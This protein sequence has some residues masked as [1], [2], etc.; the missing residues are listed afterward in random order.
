MSIDVIVNGQNYTGFI[1]AKITINFLDASGVASFS[2][3]TLDLENS[4][5]PLRVQDEVQVIIN[6]EP[7]ITGFI[8]KLSN[9]IDHNSQSIKFSMRDK[10]G[11]LVDSTL[12][13]E[14]T[15]EINAP[16]SLKIIC[17][18]ILKSLNIDMNVIDNSGSDDFK[19]KGDIIIPKLKDTAFHFLEEY[20]QKRQVILRSDGAGNLVLDRGS[21][22]AYITSLN[23][24]KNT[25][26]NNIK[27]RELIADFTARYN[28]YILESQLS[29][30]TI[31]LSGYDDSN[32]ST[33]LDMTNN[34]KAIS[35]DDQVRRSRQYAFCPTVSY[36]NESANN[37]AIWENNIRR[38]Q[39]LIYNC[40]VAGFNADQD[41]EIWK[42]NRLVLVNDT[43]AD[44]SEE[45]LIDS[46]SYNVSV[47]GGETCDLK[48]V[49]KDAYQLQSK[50]DLRT[51]TT[52]NNANNFI[53]Y[54]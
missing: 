50:K 45:M 38:A 40:T 43:F 3:N 9:F 7:V 28:K 22:D 34:I 35:I 44:I 49:S 4:I 52:D 36:E 30:G 31:D 29:G 25:L 47:G 42:V 39:S 23:L 37:R 20:A 10:T 6:K 41:D 51:S 12:D 46:V 11:D 24:T 13:S 26:S 19:T 14:N 27:S 21:K 54:K 33:L 48:L 5:Y 2:A 8:D 16:I 15:N 32:K 17:E 1:N 18:I 53:S